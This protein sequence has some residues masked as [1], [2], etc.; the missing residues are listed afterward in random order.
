MR[1]QTLIAL[2]RGINVG[3]K[4]LI[5]MSELRAGCAELGWEDVRTYVNSGNL[6]LRT[7]ARAAI[8]E[9]ELE[10]LVERRFGLAI[11]VIVRRAAEWPG[12]MRGNPF[13]EASAKEPNLVMLALAK[14][15]PKADAATAL[16]ERATGG[17]RVVRA[18]DA[19]WI[20]FAK[21]VAKSKLSPGMIDTV[22]GSPVTTRNWRTVVK[23]D[24]MARGGSR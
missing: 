23:L 3:G 12:I 13:P 5:S 14:A 15:K 9:G 4:N 17:E 7:D 11:P 19:I 21:G 22:V 2:L 8:V 24:E 16:E 20:L 10:R 18:G 6:V 1:D